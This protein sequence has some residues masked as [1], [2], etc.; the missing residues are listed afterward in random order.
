MKELKLDLITITKGTFTRLKVFLENTSVFF[1]E[2]NLNEI[3][4]LRE[5][6][7]SLDVESS[8]KVF[9]TFSITLQL[10]LIFIIGKSVKTTKEFFYDEGFFD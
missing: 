9:D 5:V 2:I 3:K 7:F 1:Q 10:R 4:K 6:S 8:L